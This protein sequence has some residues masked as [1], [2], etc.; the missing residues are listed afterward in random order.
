MEMSAKQR[1]RWLLG[2]IWLVVWFG[3][4]GPLGYSQP[5]EGQ[6]GGLY[7][8]PDGIGRFLL[9]GILPLAIW[10]VVAGYRKERAER[11]AG[12]SESSTAPALPQQYPPKPADSEPTTQRRLRPWAYV[13]AAVTL[14]LLLTVLAL[15]WQVR[16]LTDRL[17]HL[18]LDVYLLEHPFPK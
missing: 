6:R 7:L 4:T 9:V 15:G 14:V 12:P 2:A 13:S 10:W 1:L 17:Q 16:Q 5:Y 8:V 3:I 11:A 18:E